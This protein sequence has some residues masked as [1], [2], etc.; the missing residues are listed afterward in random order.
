[1]LFLP[2]KLKTVYILVSVCGS[3]LM[4]VQLEHLEERYGRKKRQ[5]FDKR[6]A[7]IG[8]TVVV[9]AALAFFVFGGFNLDAS[10]TDATDL[11]HRIVSDTE[12]TV[13]FEL[14]SR[15]NRPVACAVEALSNSHGPVGYKVIDVK[16]SPERTRTI[17]ETLVTTQ[18]AATISAKK[19]WIVEE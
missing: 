6:F 4:S 2:A 17:T 7:W 18:R 8:V 5:K 3:E 12:A 9:L 13:T 14:N 11:K 10:D 1:M 19:C 16:P 15:P